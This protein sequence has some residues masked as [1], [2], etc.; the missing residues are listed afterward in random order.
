MLS[1]KWWAMG[2]WANNLILCFCLF[3]CKIQVITYNCAQAWCR[4]YSPDS[5][6]AIDKPSICYFKHLYIRKLKSH[7]SRFTPSYDTVDINFFGK[8]N[9]AKLKHAVSFLSGLPAYFLGDFCITH[10]CISLAQQPVPIKWHLAPH[11][12]HCNLRGLKGFG[13]SH[14][15]WLCSVY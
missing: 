5:K 11:L 4:A 14:P 15:F 1:L 9:Q 10:G 2:Y 13:L 8:E 12:G 6:D 7:N 3:T